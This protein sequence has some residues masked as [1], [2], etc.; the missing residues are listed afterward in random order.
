MPALDCDAIVM[1]GGI[2]STRMPDTGPAMAQF[3]AT[4]HTV[5]ESV[6]A[7]AISSPSPTRVVSENALADPTASPDVASDAVHAI[8]T[9]AAC[10]A[11]SA[12]AHATRGGEASRLIVIVLDAGVPVPP[13]ALHV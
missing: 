1:A 12:L 11:A 5:R 13:T 2:L 4:S 3:P 8:V 9:S 10:H 6:D 7:D